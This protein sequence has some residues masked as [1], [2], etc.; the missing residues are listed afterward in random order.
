M[1]QVLCLGYNL[2]AVDL[3]AGPWQGYVWKEA[4][5]QNLAHQHYPARPEPLRMTWRDS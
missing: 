3:I 1:D 4:A 5:A 2:H